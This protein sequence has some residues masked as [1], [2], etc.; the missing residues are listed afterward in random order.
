MAETTSKSKS[1]YSV[2]KNRTSKQIMR[3]LKT[4]TG[5]AVM[6]YTFTH[7]YFLFTVL[8]YAVEK[9]TPHLLLLVMPIA[10][11]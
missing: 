9:G 11:C 3:I 1:M 5:V 6:L 8:T 2:F 4:N 10:L 7:H